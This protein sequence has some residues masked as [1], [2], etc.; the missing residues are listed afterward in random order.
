MENVT[1]EY[2]QDAARSAQVTRDHLND[3]AS[4]RNNVSVLIQRVDILEKKWL[5]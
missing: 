5:R 4:E 2:S 1:R 3:T